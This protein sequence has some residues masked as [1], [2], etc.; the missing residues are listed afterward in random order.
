MPVA[1]PA[2]L[3]TNLTSKGG[4]AELLDTLPLGVAIM[5]KK[6]TLLAVNK[7]YESLI[8]VER[9]TVLGI[10][11]L[12]ALRCE[13]CMKD[14]PIMTGWKDKQSHTVETNIVNRAREKVPVH[15]T[16]APLL[17][18]KGTIRA[19]VETVSSG[20]DH[21]LDEI[22][23]GASG[24]GELVGRSP[25]VRKI[26]AMTPSIAQTD[27]PVL[28]TGETGTGKDM[29]AEEIHNESDRDGP[30]VKVN[31]GALPEPLLE[32]ELFGHAK[33]ALPGADHAKP[34]RLRMAH[35][36]TLF[37]TEIGELPLALQTKLLA[38]MDDHTVR[39]MGSTKVIHTDVR[40][41]A[42]SHYDLE[43]RVRRKRFRQ[44]L[45]Y[46]LNVI[47]LNLPP[48]R[49]RG[50]DLLLLQD[51]FLKMFQARYGKKVDRFSTNVDTLLKS[52]AFPGNVRELRNLIEYAVNFCD[53]NVIRMR[54]LPGYM[55]HGPDLP[56]KLA[57]PAT[58]NPH[59]PG[60]VR[61]V[62]PERWEDVQRK[63]IL[64][65]LVKA[66]GRKTQAAALLGWGR[67]TLWRK[68][69]HFGIE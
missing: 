43:E 10:R 34:G 18:D 16:L 62:P 65:A 44:D 21:V 36:G 57:V 48:L 42:A 1:D 45:L 63:M 29:L 19:I 38:Y 46:R 68:M 32:S 52:Y 17:G 58:L 67:S 24:L 35:G 31:C 12:H 60:E 13:F 49:E 22:G 20:S 27:S 7:R 50:E 6:G 39:P 23:S 56:E 11:C 66:N 26:F 3:I 53:S 28:I 30:F 51:H 4:L 54:H 2:A 14:C 41:M 37:F 69:K 61:S 9:N 15:L 33:H 5:D 59:T 8:G 25:Q 55:L 47:R 64:D 40:I